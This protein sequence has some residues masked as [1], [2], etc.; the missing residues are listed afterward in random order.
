MLTHNAA[1]EIVKNYTREI[2]VQ[3]V[4]VMDGSIRQN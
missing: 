4:H 2:Q 1:I 3:G